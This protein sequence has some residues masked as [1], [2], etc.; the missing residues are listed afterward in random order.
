[1]FKDV[2]V[3][4]MTKQPRIRE[5]LK[6]CER[7]RVDSEMLLRDSALLRQELR[8]LREEAEALCNL[9]LAQGE[10]KESQGNATAIDAAKA[11]RTMKQSAS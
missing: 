9:L 6:E 4:T 1:M 10:E 5:L 2:S 11:V 7:L 3:R 8:N